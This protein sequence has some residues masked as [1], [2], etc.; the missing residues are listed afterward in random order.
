MA[1]DGGRGRGDR[2]SRREPQGT[3]PYAEGSGGD[4]GPVDIVAVRRDDALIDAIAAGGPVPTES[5]EEFQLAALLADWRTEIITPPLPDAPDLDTVVAAVNQEI[6]ARQARVAARSGGRLRLL[7][8]IA[9]TA[10]A[11]ALVIGGMTAFSYAA[12]PGDPLWGVKEVVFSQQAQATVVQ[13]ADNDMAAAQTL[14]DQGDP[15]QARVRLEQAAANTA[16][17]DDPEKRTDLMDL[18]QRLLAELRKVSPEAAQQLERSVPAVPPSV[19]PDRTQLPSR[20][21]NAVP[22][23]SGRTQ[24]PGTPPPDT[25]SESPS[26]LGTEE[27]GQ[28]GGPQSTQPAGPQQPTRPSGPGATIAPGPGTGVPNLPDV[29]DTTVVP[30]PSQDVLPPPVTPSTVS[31]PSPAAPSPV[32]P[33]P[34]Q[35]TV[36]SGTGV[37][38]P[39][40]NPDDN[41]GPSVPTG[42]PQ[43]P[44]MGPSGTAPSGT[45]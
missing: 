43:L 40:T 24:T 29:P 12:E 22:D 1:R 32:Q 19:E 17:V 20:P 33:T 23:T 34:V 39:P 45:N 25:T 3:G 36:D 4:T 31:S 11:V 16:R 35:P 13:R 21:G 44:G 8:P 10:A 28:P 5:T 15:E 27:P 2:K 42:I 41:G 6:G 38:A 14:I 37:P 30:T 26:I 7:R 9:G 18:W